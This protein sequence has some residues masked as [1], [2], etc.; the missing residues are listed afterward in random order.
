MKKKFL[1][2]SIRSALI[3]LLPTLGFLMAVP[4][5]HA[6]LIGVQ[7]AWP[8]ITTNASDISYVYSSGTGG[9]L[10]ING[11]AGTGA[12]Y[13]NQTIKFFSGDTVHNICQGT[14]SS[15]NPSTT[16]SL[17]ANFN[18]SGIFTNGT[19]TIGGYIDASSA[20]GYQAVDYNGAAPGGTPTGTLLTA[21]LTAFGFNGSAGASTYDLLKLD[22]N[23]TLTGGDF[24]NSIFDPNNEVSLIANAYRVYSGSSS[25]FTAPYGQNWDSVASPFTKSF[26]CGNGDNTNRPCQQA[27]IDTFVPVPAAV[28][29]LGSGLIGLLGIATRSRKT[30]KSTFAG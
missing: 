15:C 20:S 11:N 13:V 17:I 16:Y 14:T 1:G 5:A 25:P 21:N 26:S 9:T 23:G 22:F 12:A 6:A 24:Y 29:L 7:P 10:T 8:D 3:M 27:G 30:P 28:W 2:G 4:S 19:L 18:T